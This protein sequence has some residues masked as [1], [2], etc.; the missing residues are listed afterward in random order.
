[1]LEENIDIINWI[2]LSW[3]KNAIHLLEQNQDKINWIELS[4]N[5]NA[6]HL[7]KKQNKIEWNG[8]LQNPSI[9]EIDYQ[10]LQ[11]RINLLKKNS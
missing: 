4:E 11:Q 9:F 3:N 7:L 2:N 1:M 8:I 5:P 6:V 10:V